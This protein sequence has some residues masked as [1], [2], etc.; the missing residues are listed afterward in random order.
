MREDAE[1]GN[2]LGSVTAHIGSGT[3]HDNIM[4]NITSE[5][6]PFTLNSHNV[7]KNLL[8]FTSI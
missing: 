8:T 3:G 6:T 7:S 1:A 4:Y 5:N 2:A